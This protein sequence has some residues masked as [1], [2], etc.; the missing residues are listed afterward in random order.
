MDRELFENPVLLL[1]TRARSRVYVYVRWFGVNIIIAKF[2]PNFTSPV[3]L[4]RFVR[5]IYLRETRSNAASRNEAFDL[6]ELILLLSAA[7]ISRLYNTS[8]SARRSPRR[9][10][11][12]RGRVHACEI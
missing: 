12:A 2:H 7:A 8:L 5:D 10:L 9:N 11:K 1:H 6:Q 4:P 3:E